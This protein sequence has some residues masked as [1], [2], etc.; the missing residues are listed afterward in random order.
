M[1]AGA[2][3]ERPFPEAMGPPDASPDA[4]DGPIPSRGVLLLAHAR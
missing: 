1:T 3:G 4:S 2:P